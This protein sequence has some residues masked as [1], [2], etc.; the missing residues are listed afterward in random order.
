MYRQ[1][2]VQQNPQH[3]G[4]EL[5]NDHLVYL[6]NTEAEDIKVLPTYWLIIPAPSIAE[7]ASLA[8]VRYYF[9]VTPA[10]D[11]SRLPKIIAKKSWSF[12][13]ITKG[14]CHRIQLKPEAYQQFDTAPNEDFKQLDI[15]ILHLLFME[16]IPGIPKEEKVSSPFIQYERSV[17]NCLLKVSRDEAVLA[18]ITNGVSIKRIK[19]VC[20][21]GH[22]FPQKS[23]YFYPK[24]ICGFLFASIQENE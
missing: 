8:R 15:V 10:P 13:F 4:E 12:S 21:S 24:T 23:T 20:Y 14:K 18:I 6:I 16:K 2:G 11:A 1:K 7:E 9:S 3:S 19:E 17:S 5:Y 22:V